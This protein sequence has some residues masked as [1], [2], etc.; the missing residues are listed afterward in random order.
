MTKISLINKCFPKNK[1]VNRFIKDIIKIFIIVSLG[2][3]KLYGEREY[4]FLGD[5]A[6]VVIEVNHWLN[7]FNQTS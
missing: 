1:M 2:K 7:T 6:K 3:F 5:R 4:F